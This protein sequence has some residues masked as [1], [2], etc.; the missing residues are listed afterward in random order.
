VYNLPGTGVYVLSTLLR[1][2]IHVTAVLR[3]MT[4]KVKPMATTAMVDTGS[5]GV[6]NVLVS[7]DFVLRTFVN[8]VEVK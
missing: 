4:T 2:L 8:G 3:K 5:S 6:V 1:R 7:I